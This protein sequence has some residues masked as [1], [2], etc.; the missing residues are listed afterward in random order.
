[1][2]QAWCRILYYPVSG[3][4]DLL[5]FSIC[6]M[7]LCVLCVCV[8]LSVFL[9]QEPRPSQQLGARICRIAAV[10][11]GHFST[12]QRTAPAREG[13][14]GGGEEESASGARWAAP[15]LPLAGLLLTPHWLTGLRA[16][17]GGARGGWMMGEES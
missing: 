12:R 5:E 16:T 17:R 2:G 1:M 4:S 9:S 15:S 3:I 8:S 6:V 7:Y 11:V 14:T 13:G 10:A